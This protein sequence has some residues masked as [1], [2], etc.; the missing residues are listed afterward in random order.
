MNW[1]GFWKALTDTIEITVIVGIIFVVF[2]FSILTYFSS[3]ADKA[4]YS[5]IMGLGFY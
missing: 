1:I 5:H 3:D 4:A 2:L